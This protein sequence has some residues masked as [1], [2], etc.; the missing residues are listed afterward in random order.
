MGK[1]YLGD[2]VKV[3]FPCRNQGK[4]GTVIRNDRVV[5]VKFDDGTT[6]SFSSGNSLQLVYSSVW[7]VS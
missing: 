1:F 3:L 4:I 2:K 7:S 6:T 5:K